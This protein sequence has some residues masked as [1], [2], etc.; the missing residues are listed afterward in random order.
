M[1]IFS[2]ASLKIKK[3]LTHQQFGKRNLCCTRKGGWCAHCETKRQRALLLLLRSMWM[4]SS[5]HS[6]FAFMIAFADSHNLT[7][8]EHGPFHGDHP[9]PGKPTS[10]N[11]F[12]WFVVTSNLQISS[13]Q[14]LGSNLFKLQ[15]H[16]C[17]VSQIF[18]H[19]DLKLQILT[20]GNRN[21]AIGLLAGFYN[22][23]C[24][25]HHMATCLGLL[26]IPWC[27]VSRKWWKKVEVAPGC[28][29]WN[30]DFVSARQWFCK[31][32]GCWFSWY[33]WCKVIRSWVS[34]C[35][36][37]SILPVLGKVP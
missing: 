37:F 35:L 3:S 1:L 9:L 4:L 26:S 5:I 22:Y 10:G 18:F 31:S 32:H 30:L 25:G 27:R 14:Q 6:K 11:M 24:A 20:P 2:V 36:A 28:L 15:K 7:S 12:L 13:T 8:T 33:G 21:K 17:Q 29:G 19:G 16:M 23:S 34:I